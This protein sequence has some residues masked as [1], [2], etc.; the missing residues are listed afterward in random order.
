MCDFQRM[1]FGSADVKPTN[2][3]LALNCAEARNI[4]KHFHIRNPG[5]CL[6]CTK[7]IRFAFFILH[8]RRWC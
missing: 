6:F 8:R 5:F 7:K 2:W 1:M 3:S 4:S